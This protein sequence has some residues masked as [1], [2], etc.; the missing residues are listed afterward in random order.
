MSGDD[1]HR[2]AIDRFGWLEPFD[3]HPLWP[4]GFLQ[5]VSVKTL[6]PDLDVDTH[7]A[8]VGFDVVGDGTP[9]DVLSGYHFPTLEETDRPLVVVL[10]GMG[11][12]ARSGY[13]RSMAATLLGAGY[14]VVLW[15]NRGAGGSGRHCRKYHHPGYTEDLRLL[16]DHLRRERPLWCRGGLAAVAFSLGANLLL[17]YL[18]ESGDRSAFRAAASVSAPID[19]EVVSRNLR[20]GKNQ[21][22]DRYL[23]KKQRD[24]LLRDGVDLDD[25]ERERIR[26][27][28]S[29]WALDDTFTGPTLGYDGAAAYYADNSAASVIEDIRTP[30]LIFHAADDPVVDPSVLTDRDWPDGGPLYPALT[31][32]GGH[33]GYLHRDGTRWHE[34]ATRNFFDAVID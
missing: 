7:P 12:H 4:G 1:N 23:L 6:R 15:N 13:M 19:M 33:T 24:E 30:T 20:H 3:P 10:H 11:G 9:P 8:A 5:T 2:E 29:V 22:F 14:P 26:T 27:A 31:D 21:L 25:D 28:S 16:V 34:T 32:S 18:G 17:K